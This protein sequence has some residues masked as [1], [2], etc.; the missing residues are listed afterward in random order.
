MCLYLSLL[1]RVTFTAP[2]QLRALLHTPGVT[3]ASPSQVQ[4]RV[5]QLVDL[6]LKRFD[7]IG[8]SSSSGPWRRKAVALALVSLLP[9]DPQVLQHLD[10]ILNVCIDVL[11]ELRGGGGGSEAAGG[12]AA[13]AGVPEAYAS[14]H[15]A[16][17]EALASDLYTAN[18][19]AMLQGD[20]VQT[21]DLAAFLHQ[22][23]GEAQVAVGAAAFQ[24]VLA[25]IDPVILQQL[26]V[27]ASPPA[28]R[29]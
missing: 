7:H 9:A 28:P 1:A 15:L 8:A 4:A 16:Q 26:Q 29:E 19:R 2:E 27:T 13:A 23:M 22:K 24:Q 11:A 25:A 3:D 17:D 6:W 21:T 20:L 14:F 12:E 5:L 10:L 18:L